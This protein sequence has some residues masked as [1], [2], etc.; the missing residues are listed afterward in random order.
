MLTAVLAAAPSHAVDRRPAVGSAT[1]DP[2]TARGR[3]ETLDPSERS[4]A[5]AAARAFLATRGGDWRFE[6]DRRTG[7]MALVEGSGIPLVPG[8]GNSLPR[9]SGATD[10][11]TIEGL[12][13]LA[14][15]LIRQHSALLEPQRGEL[16]LDR[17]RSVVRDHGRLASLR[18][19]WYVDG[20]RVEG[21]SV[22]VRVNSG[23]VTQIGAPLIGSI[24]ALVISSLLVIHFLDD[25]FTE[26]GAY[27]PPD[28][29]ATTVRLI[30]K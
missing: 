10:P 11:P 20:V 14:R 26:D 23:N 12:E 16:V 18:F 7:R 24:T 3:S 25:P 15:A 9:G 21:A 4:A 28:Q 1:L 5:G 27:I 29:M 22:F 19:E 2:A 6:L 13:P 17:L 30:V 8:R